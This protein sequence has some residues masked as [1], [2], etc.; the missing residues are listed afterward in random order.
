MLAFTRC[1]GFVS[2]SV[3]EYCHLLSFALESPR[4]QDSTTFDLPTTRVCLL[5]YIRA[6][7]RIF[8]HNTTPSPA[9]AHFPHSLDLPR[10]LA[11]TLFLIYHHK[12]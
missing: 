11:S 9:H 10:T 7:P 5:L 6:T 2:H 4:A 8:H 1:S 3:L 12:E